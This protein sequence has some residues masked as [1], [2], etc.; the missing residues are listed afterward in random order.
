MAEYK[1][2]VSSSQEGPTSTDS[3]Q[4]STG[5]KNTT[6]NRTTDFTSSGDRTQTVTKTKWALDQ[7]LAPDR[8]MEFTTFLMFMQQ[9][10][11]DEE[12]GLNL[13]A[14][15]GRSRSSETAWELIRAN[16]TNLGLADLRLLMWGATPFLKGVTDEVFK[17]LPIV[18]NNSLVQVMMQALRRLYHK[19]RGDDRS[20]IFNWVKESLLPIQCPAVSNRTDEERLSG[21]GNLGT[22]ANE[23]PS[24]SCGPDW[25]DEHTLSML[26]LFLIDAPPTD[27]GYITPQQLCQLFNDSGFAEGISGMFDIDPSRGKLLLS[28]LM[29]QCVNPRE[30]KDVLRLGALACF[31]DDVGSLGN[32][33]ARELLSHLKACSNEEARKNVEMLTLALAKENPLDEELLT[34][35]ETEASAL[36]STQLANISD[37]DVRDSVSDLGRRRGWTDG[38][39]RLLIGKF[40]KAGG[41]ISSGTDLMRMGTLI[42]GL[43]SN[44]LRNLSG[45][46]FL[47]AVKEG[48]EDRANDLSTFQR[49]IIVDTILQ[50]VNSTA[51]VECLSGSLIGE[52]PLYAIQTADIRSLEEVKGKRWN[53][54]QALYLCE[55]LIGNGS[56]PASE[57]RQLGPIVQGVTCGMI[58]GYGDQFG[59]EMAQALGVNTV[60]LSRKQLS[61]AAQKLKSSL[62]KIQPEY[63]SDIKDAEFRGIPNAF[64]LHLGEEIC[65][66]PARICDSFLEKMAGAE[67]ELL[68]RSSA[69]RACLREEALRCLNK[70][71]SALNVSEVERLG[72]LV[73]EFTGRDVSD[74]AATVFNASIQQFRKCRQFHAAAGNSLRAELLRS[75]GNISEWT[76]DTVTSLGSMI[77]LLGGEILLQLPDTTSVKDALLQLTASQSSPSSALSPEFDTTLDLTAVHAKIFNILVRAAAKPDSSKAQAVSSCSVAPTSEQ[78]RELGEANSEWAGEQLA[79][80]SAQTF[81]DTVEEL[82]SVSGFSKEQHTAL[83]DKA[84]EA[85]G[86]V[87]N[88]TGED[89]A[90]LKC[91]VTTLSV[92]ELQQLEL[93]SIDTLAGISAC[94][95]WTQEQQSAVLGRFL[96]L[97]GTTAAALGPVDLS[98]LGN[99]VCGMNASL[100]S[101]LRGEAIRLAAAS[102]GRLTCPAAILDKLKEKVAVVFGP[103]KEW[104]AAQLSELGTV[105]AGSSTDDLKSLDPQMMPFLSTTAV[106][107]IPPHRFRALSVSQLNS[108]GPANAAAVTEEQMKGASEEQRAAVSEALGIPYHRVAS[109][110]KT[111]TGGAASPVQ[112]LSFLGLSLLT[113]CLP[114]VLLAVQ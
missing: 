80:M 69:V 32:G 103:V 30:L 38:Q 29:G 1:G 101:Q 114:A 99:F 20:D 87:S 83:K 42:K 111:P 12:Y 4:V 91:I 104:S 98:G 102:L 53:R 48:L 107:L 78:I 55:S 36:Y 64:L 39:S 58:D 44:V 95:A 86:P 23:L 18:R 17:G 68:P 70:P 108:L 96:K 43:P 13:T 84:V 63:F 94:P 112:S 54:G 71:V 47:L 10:T 34:A 40:L 65:Q 73:C 45:E 56:V 21:D 15:M 85:W 109:S 88:F 62:N 60:W 67:L 46:Q 41:Q 16:L 11:E 7:R 97:S 79:C 93:S 9:L 25:I 27:F 24:G 14:C 3:P 105:A 113:Q 51:A 110:I 100:V 72:V 8:Q 61:C 74:L 33:S 6:D 89:I 49:K 19:L 26:G 5:Q 90:I 57:V 50:G 28:K 66:L 92:S 31:Y 81:E 106:G 35:L 2:N 77:T 52:L 82:A 75:L 22:T 59:L 76:A 37:Q